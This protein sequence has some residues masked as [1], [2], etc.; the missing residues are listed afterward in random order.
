M[1]GMSCCVIYPLMDLVLPQTLRTDPA[2]VRVAKGVYALRAL[3]GDRPY[4][5]VGRPKKKLSKAE[6]SQQAG[7]AQQAGPSAKKEGSKKA[8]P[9]QPSSPETKKRKAGAAGPTAGSPTKKAKQT[10]QAELEQ[11]PEEQ[12]R[13][14]PVRSIEVRNQHRLHSRSLRRE[15]CRCRTQFGSHPDH[16]HVTCRRRRSI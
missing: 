11:Q 14:P 4:E 8:R 15:L 10:K 6:G 7:A 9:A 13:L 16:C 5:A 2:F 12:D 1:I 3:M